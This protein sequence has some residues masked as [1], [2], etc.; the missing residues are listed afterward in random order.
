MRD[1][2]AEYEAHQAE[3]AERRAARRARYTE[4]DA[5]VADVRRRMRAVRIALNEVSQEA[6]NAEPGAYINTERSIQYARSACSALKQDRTQKHG[7]HGEELLK[8]AQ[9]QARY[10]ENSLARLQAAE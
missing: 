5:A 3:L 1:L 4:Q 10:A 7:R 2:K 6:V 8:R 9:D